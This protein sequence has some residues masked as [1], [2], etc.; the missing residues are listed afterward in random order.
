M[1][2]MTKSARKILDMLRGRELSQKEI[3]K[4]SG[5]TERAVRYIL[6]DLLNHELINIRKTSRDRRLKLYSVASEA[7]G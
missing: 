5:M 6:E 2:T 3:I 1:S 7:T 4:R